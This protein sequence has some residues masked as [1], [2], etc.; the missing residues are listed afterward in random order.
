MEPERRLTAV[1]RRE[2]ILHAAA[3]VFGARGYTATTTDQVARAAG[4]SQ[5]YVVRMFGTKETLFLE[6][7]ERSRVALLEAFRAEIARHRDAGGPDED[8]LD[9][10]GD[11]YIDLIRDRGIHLPLMQAFLQGADPVIGAKAR[12]GFLDIHHL[13]LTEAGCSVE[14]ARDFLAQGMLVN[15]L[16]GLRMPVI[17]DADPEAA[18]LLEATCGSRLPFLAEDLA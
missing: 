9:S 15:V 8:L 3:E 1:E 4:I 2:Q 6:V 7:L 11:T 14:E 17:A 13:L 16:L 12:Q 10:L 18:A 5:P